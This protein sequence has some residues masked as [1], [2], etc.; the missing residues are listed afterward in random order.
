M[1]KNW[2]DMKK[3]YPEYRDEMT[4]D[5]ERRFV[6]DCFALYEKEGYN[7]YFWSQGGDFKQYHGEPFT[8]LG[9]AKEDLDADL[10]CLPMWKIQFLNGPIICAYP[11]EIIPSEMRDA[12]CPKKYL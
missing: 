10:E 12:G 11:D 8:V 5:R 2:D 4:K 6:N 9:R 1:I 7:K 3:E